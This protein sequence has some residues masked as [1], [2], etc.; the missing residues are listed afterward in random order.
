MSQEQHSGLGT[1]M[2]QWNRQRRS[3]SPDAQEALHLG[4]TEP[5][6]IAGYAHDQAV[7]QYCGATTATSVA[8]YARRATRCRD[9]RG[10]RQRGGSHRGGARLGRARVQAILQTTRQMGAIS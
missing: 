9:S 8:A 2:R 6:E 5:G 10:S 4:R 3:Y 1:C 7:T